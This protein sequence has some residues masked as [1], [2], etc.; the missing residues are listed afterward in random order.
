MNATFELDLT[1]Q[2]MQYLDVVTTTVVSVRASEVTPSPID[3]LW[4]PYLQRNA[5]NAYYGNPSVGKGNVGIDNIACLTTGRPFPTETTTTRDPMNVVMMAAEEG[6]S[7]TIVPRLMSAKADLDRVRIIQSVRMHKNGDKIDDRLVTFQSDIAYIR[8]DMRPDEKFLFIDPITNYVGDVNFNQDG[9]VRPV[10]TTLAQ[11]AEELQITVLMVGHFNKNSSVSSAMDK[12]SGARAWTA[13]PRNVWGF[14]RDI[15][16]REN[17][18]MT[19]LK[20]NNAKE[21]ETSLLFQIDEH[22]I[23]TKPNGKPWMMPFVVWGEKS[24]KTAEEM[25]AAERPE[26]RRDNKGVVF[27]NSAIRSAPRK[28]DEIYKEAD[29]KGISEPTI[30]RACNTIGVIKYKTGDGWFWQH[31]A[32]KTPIPA[33]A[34]SWNDEAKQRRDEQTVKEV[35]A[36]L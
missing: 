13:V 4:A 32:D 27:V 1:P 10:L 9:E 17:R 28:A 12:A 33:T 16:D 35:Q 21:S 23:G 11:L 20:M 22:E 5:L 7:D 2:P 34:I 3:F 18:Y 30:K 19:N 31:P 24:D 29:D 26:A 36:A 14:F 25:I 6:I 15:D 8:E